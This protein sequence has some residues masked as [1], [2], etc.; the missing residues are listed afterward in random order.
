MQ[1]LQQQR[2]QWLQG[3][4]DCSALLCLVPA[5]R[6]QFTDVPTFGVPEMPKDGDEEK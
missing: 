4:I 1:Q 6:A 3:D 5:P 2:I